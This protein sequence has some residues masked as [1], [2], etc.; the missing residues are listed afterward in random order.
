MKRVISNGRKKVN[1][2]HSIISNRYIYLSARRLLLLSVFRRSIEYGSEV[3]KCNKSQAS[4]LE[5]IL[6]GGAKRI[7]GCS[8]KTCNEA[9]RGDMGLETLKS[10]R[11][12]A[13]LNWWY[14]PASVSVRRY[15]RQLFNQEWKVKPH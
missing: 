13:K 11:D 2:L 10:R 12:K 5:S 6:L 4:A 8:S 3:W 7:L 14:K 1:Q 15:P 9:G